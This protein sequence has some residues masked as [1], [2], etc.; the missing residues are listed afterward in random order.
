FKKDDM[1]SLTSRIGAIIHTRMHRIRYIWAFDDELPRVLRDVEFSLPEG[2]VMKAQKITW[3]DFNKN[4]YVMDA[5]FDVKAVKGDFHSFQ[6]ESDGFPRKEGGTRF[7]F[8]PMSNKV[9]RVFLV[10]TQQKRLAFQVFA[11]ALIALFFLA[12]VFALLAV[13]KKTAQPRGK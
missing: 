10:R 12:A 4:E 1:E 7:D 2:T 8:D 6:L 11:I 5:P 13:L 9:F 3:S